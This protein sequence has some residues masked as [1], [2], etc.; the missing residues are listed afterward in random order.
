MIK[1]DAALI[2]HNLSTTMAISKKNEYT[3]NI[4]CEVSQYCY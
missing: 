2:I 4:F 1:I 3:L